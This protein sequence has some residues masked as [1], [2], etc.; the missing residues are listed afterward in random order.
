[1]TCSNNVIEYS[2]G[3]TI[4]TPVHFHTDMENGST[5]RFVIAVDDT[6]SPIIDKVFNMNSDGS[7]TIE[8][9]LAERS[10]LKLGKYIY[11]A[12]VNGIDG[13]IRTRQSGYFIVTWFAAHN[14]VINLSM[15]Y[16]PL[17]FDNIPTEGSS[18]PVTSDGI[19]AA[20]SK[21]ADATAVKNIVIEKDEDWKQLDTPIPFIGQVACPMG[22]I[23]TAINNNGNFQSERNNYE[24]SLTE[25]FFVYSYIDEDL[26]DDDSYMVVQQ[27]FDIYGLCWSRWILINKFNGE[28]TSRQMQH[29][30]SMN[31]FSTK[32]QT[33]KKI[34]NAVTALKLQ[35][36]P[37]TT[38]SGYPITIREHLTNEKLISC[39]IHGADGGVG[40]LQEDGSYKI[41]L[42]VFG[43]NIFNPDVLSVISGGT[44]GYLKITDEDTDM[45]MSLRI[46]DSSVE[47]PP[48]ASIMFT[49]R[50]YDARMEDGGSATYSVP[51]LSNGMQRAEY[52]LNYINGIRLRYFSFYPNSKAMINAIKA[53]FDIQ[54]EYGKVATDI[55]IYTPPAEIPIYVDSP[56]L[57]GE[58]AKITDVVIPY[59]QSNTIWVNTK[60][61]PS[62]IEVEYYQDINKVITEL[63]NAILAQGG[64]V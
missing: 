4:N 25:S 63:K 10:I 34:S 52:I 27:I 54:I 29:R 39:T 1:M 2:I 11:K 19:C 15:G 7:F 26:T 23:D 18:N 31:D 56:L 62:K 8:L 61:E 17:V 47:L 6:S 24:W 16:K 48:G 12:I 42:S 13:S 60:V 44:Y 58:K 57:S 35:S 51:L 22:C 9:T 28:V 49:Y 50:G 5:M 36:V 41:S 33:D 30:F 21:K 43:K 53:R 32:S 14:N 64:N 45:V 3:D 20:L 37:R 55:E 59:S 46:K 38:V 40:D